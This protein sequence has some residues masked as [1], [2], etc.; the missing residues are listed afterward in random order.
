MRSTVKVALVASMA[1]FIPQSSFTLAQEA[2]VP[3]VLQFSGFVESVS[4]PDIKSVTFALYRDQSGGAPLWQ[5]TQNVAVDGQG[6]FR[7]S[8]GATTTGGLP[9]ELFTNSEPRWLGIV[10]NGKD[11]GERARVLLG[12]VPY[13]LKA[14]DADTL[15]GQPLSAFVLASSDGHNPLHPDKSREAKSDSLSSSATTSASRINMSF[16]DGTV[17][18]NIL[19]KFE[20]VA[21]GLL[22]NSNVADVN[23]LIGIG[24]LIP[25]YNL[26]VKG[27]LV[28]DIRS[29]GDAYAKFSWRVNG[30]GVDQKS[31]QFFP[32]TFDNSFVLG[33]LNDAENAA[34]D[35]MKIFRGPGIGINSVTFPN[36]KV[37]IGTTNPNYTLHVKGGAIA[38]IRSEGDSYAK[39]SWKVNNGGVDQKTWQF[40][41]QTFDNSLVLGTVNDPG[42]AGQNAIQIFRG[43]G[44]NINSVTF[45]NGNVGV[46]T[47]VP[48]AKLD[49]AGDINLPNTANPS[50]GVLRLGGSRFLHAY[51]DNNTFVGTNAGNF[52]LDSS[53]GNGN[54]NTAIGS[55]ALSS[56]TRGNTN[57]AIG[58]RAMEQ[59]TIGTQNTAI[60]S[61]ALRANT[62]GLANTAT[63]AEALSHN[64]TGDHNT[65]TGQGALGF[66]TT[67]NFNTAN[68]DHALQN[69]TTGSSNTA[70]GTGALPAN[71][72]GSNN[73]AV[74]QSALASTYDGISP[75]SNNTGIGYNAGYLVKGSNNTFVGYEAGSNNLVELT[76]ATAIGANAVVSASNSL[77]LGDS[78]VSVG[79]GTSTPTAKLDVNGGVRL[80][81]G[82]AKPS[83]DGN[84]RGTFWFTQGGFGVKDTAEVCAKDAGGSYAWRVI[85]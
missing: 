68:G 62:T 9:T 84:S 5:E 25:A 27:G 41:P 39:F 44:I 78:A 58:A 69:N 67:G 37:G 36:G 76:N 24:T 73:T 82:T 4:M 28:T 29:E 21:T 15:G 2:T 60:G 26:H 13:A 19:P 16:E 34:E 38:D 56:V 77:V 83:C 3:R 47:S 10:V 42:T 22:R 31:W 43:A 1:I 80:N 18:N 11:E 64:T 12:S 65:A 55:L 32:Q 7:V 63:G 71:S 70:V 23:G 53:N 6:Q 8:L 66:N 57:T 61:F 81:T 40:F 30:G 20:D 14:A 51:G 48:S 75:S 45:P 85:Y 35:A 46:G 50:T 33:T 49:V 54:Y 79:I 74:G 72:G 52:T 59:N 17:N